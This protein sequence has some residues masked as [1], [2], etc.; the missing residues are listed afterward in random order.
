MTQG[1]NGSTASTSSGATP[2]RNASADRIEPGGLS[3][4]DFRM[5]VALVD[6]LLGIKMTEA[7]KPMVASR[8]LRRLRSLGLTDYSKYCDYLRTP[9]G[10]E[11]ERQYLLDLLTTH[12]TEFFREP[13]HFEFLSAHVLPALAAKRRGS[14]KLWSAGCSTG[15]EVYTLAMVLASAMQSSP[16]VI[17]DF[18]ILGTDVSPACVER[19]R[20]AI[21]SEAEIEGIPAPMRSRFLLRSKNSADPKVRFIP[22]LRSRASFHTLNFMDRLWKVDKVDV[23]FCRNVLIYFKPD[24]QHD[25]LSGLCRHLNPGGYL[26]ISH[27]ET[28]PAG[29]LPVV[30]VARSAFQRT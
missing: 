19:A 18:S 27:C 10:A 12:K 1:F 5:I 6:R 11:Q 21:Y 20:L 22:S 8:L 26:F 17:E 3:D 13:A 28:L 15:Q 2:V 4:R 24:I 23:V 29:D 9:Q 7:K 14:V 25:I 30:P 16:P